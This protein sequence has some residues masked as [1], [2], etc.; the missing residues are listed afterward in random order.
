MVDLYSRNFALTSELVSAFLLTFLVG[1]IVLKGRLGI[2]KSYYVAL[3]KAMI[4]LLYVAFFFNEQWSP[5]SGDTLKYM[6]G[7]ANLYDIIT[8]DFPSSV[9]SINLIDTGIWHS[10]T[11]LWFLFS[12]TTIDREKYKEYNYSIA[13]VCNQKLDK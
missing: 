8:R 6:V 7:A 11:S 9:M 10:V 4:P 1:L 13:Y 2:K 3:I 5:T 12:Y